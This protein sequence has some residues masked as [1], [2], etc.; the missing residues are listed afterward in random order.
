MANRREFLQTG[1]SVTALPPAINALLSGVASARAEGD[2]AVLHKAIF[3][4]RYAEGRAFAAAIGRFGVP[5]H[6]LRNGDVTDFW[7]D[8]L[9]MLWRE[10]P[11]AIAGSTQ[12]GP[13]FALERL[14]SERGM[15]VALRVEHQ[16]RPDGTLAHV[17]TGAPE[18]LA[19]AERLRVE[20]ID[21]PL[22]VAALLTHC[23]A[24]CRAPV[25]HTVVMPGEAPAL[26]TASVPLGS[27]RAPHSVIHYYTPKA[28]Q[29]GRDVPWDGPL[30][31]WVIAP[32]ATKA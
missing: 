16:V 14:A 26:Q 3:D 17:M 12:F 9:D 2:N 28:I 30:Y 8:E 13:L 32:A 31:S 18:T 29:E 10:R 11:A 22:L 4:D 25:E 5:L 27:P 24:D 1:V 19:L 20:R 23:R 21:W 7:Y 6:A 15:R